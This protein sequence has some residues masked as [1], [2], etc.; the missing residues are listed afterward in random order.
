[1][2]AAALPIIEALAQNGEAMDVLLGAF[3]TQDHFGDGMS[4]YGYVASNPVRRSDPGGLEWGMEDDIDDAIPD[5]TGHAL[6]ALATLNEGA[7][8]VALGLNTGLE[9]ASSLLGLDVF[10]SVDALASGKGGFW[11]ALNIVMAVNPVGKLGKAGG[12]IAKG[13]G[14]ALKAGKAGHLVGKAAQ[15]LFKILPYKAAAT[16]T[17]GW[18]GAIMAHH[19]LEARHA[20]KWGLKISTDDLPA[21]ILSREMHNKLT[22]ELFSRLRTGVEHSKDA[23]WAVYQDVYKNFPE[24]LRTIEKYFK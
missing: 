6:Y 16:L 21:V 10:E 2:N 3:D 17:R 11:E 13:F 7:K 18:G 22:G 1:M 8:W 4:L 12:A 15:H 24:W 14:W 19:I 9:I 23:V 20:R 5:R